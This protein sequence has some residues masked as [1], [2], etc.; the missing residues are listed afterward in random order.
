MLRD[1]TLGPGEPSIWFDNARLS[2]PV[3][4]E[5]RLMHTSILAGSEPVFRFDGSQAR[6]WVDETAI[7]SA[8]KTS[9]TLVRWTTPAT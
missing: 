6:V 9:A 8:G 1:C 3:P 7:A 4:A 2:I 5:L